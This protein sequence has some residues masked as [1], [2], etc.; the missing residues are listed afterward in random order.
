MYSMIVLGMSIMAIIV[1][2]LSKCISPINMMSIGLFLCGVS[3]FFVGPSLLLPNN[4]VLMAFGL[5]FCG[6]TIMLASVPQIPF[7]IKYAEIMFPFEKRKASD[8]CSAIIMFNRY[9]GMLLGP[10][11]AG[12]VT[13]FVGYRS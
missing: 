11:Y 9:L 6:C 4:L 7:M 13:E 3:N 8:L 5:F 10:I 1:P 12:H 2:Y